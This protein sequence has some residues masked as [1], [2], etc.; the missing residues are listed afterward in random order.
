MNL[1]LSDVH[2]NLINPDDVNFSAFDNKFVMHCCN[3]KLSPMT[4]SAAKG[5]S[6]TTK[7]KPFGF[8]NIFSVILRSFGIRNGTFS[9][10]RAPDSDLEKS[11]ISVISL[12]RNKE[13]R[14]MIPMFSRVSSES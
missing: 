5:P 13:Q 4:S 9:I 6:S 1:P 7:S 2:F 12:R 11:R 3:L 8:K 10:V 14:L